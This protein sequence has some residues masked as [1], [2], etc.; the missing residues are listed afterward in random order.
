MVPNGLNY[1]LWSVHKRKLCVSWN[2]ANS[3][4]DFFIS[5]IQ[6]KR[7]SVCQRTRLMC[8][9]F[10]MEKTEEQ[11]MCVWWLFLF[12]CACVFLEL[13]LLSLCLLVVKICKTLCWIGRENAMA[14]TDVSRD[15]SADS[16]WERRNV[17]FFFIWFVWFTTPVSVRIGRNHVR[18]YN[19]WICNN[20]EV[21]EEGKKEQK[22][23]KGT[24]SRGTFRVHNRM[25]PLTLS[26][27]I[28]T[29]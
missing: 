14:K 17:V 5:R 7:P 4:N 19:F 12:G 28:W 13:L 8:E 9:L 29:L 15:D 16:D 3:F 20:V 27:N 21:V 10:F 23:R 24:G 6:T 2:W 11:R 26:K 18:E 1:F 25:T 22:R